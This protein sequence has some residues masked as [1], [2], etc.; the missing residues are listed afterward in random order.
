MHGAPAVRQQRRTELLADS[1][2]RDG[3][4]GRAIAGAQA[5]AHMRLP[6]SSA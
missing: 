3:V 2:E 5:R 1:A 4:D 6:T